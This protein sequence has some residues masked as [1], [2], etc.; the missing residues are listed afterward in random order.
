MAAPT[1]P[2][3]GVEAAACCC[4]PGPPK[5]AVIPRRA[6]AANLDA[7]AEVWEW[8]AADVLVHGLPLFHVHGLGLGVLGPLRL[9]GRLRH[10]GRFSAEAVAQELASGGTMLFG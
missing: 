4:R 9:G 7:L 1:V 10:V 2:R 6:V 8:T 3:A 5:G